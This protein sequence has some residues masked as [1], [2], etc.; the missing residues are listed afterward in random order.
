MVK[1]RQNIAM[2]QRL[3]RR[4]KIKYILI[5]LSLILGG[6]GSETS[7]TLRH[8]DSVMEEHPDSAMTILS[9]IRRHT[10]KDSDLPYFALLYT[11]AQVK[12]DVPLDSDSLISIAYAKYGADTRGDRGIRS[13]FYTG[14]VFFNQKRYREAMPYYLTAYEES[15]RLSNDYW[16]AKA[17]ERINNVFFFTYNYD[18]AIKYSH[19]AAIYYNESGRKGNHRYALGQM[20]LT[21]VYNGEAERA[22]QLLD[23]LERRIVDETPVDSALLAYLK[24]PLI[25]AMVMTGRGDSIDTEFMDVSK[26]DM[27]NRDILDATILKSLIYE[28]KDRSEEV[29]DELSDIELLATSNED[30][31]HILYARYENA[32]SIGDQSLA[33]SLVDSMLYYQNMVAEEII[34]GSVTG[35]QRDF[36]SEMSLRHENRSRLLKLTLYGSIGIF[37]LLLV[38]CTVFF[39]LKIRARKAESEARLEA[40]LSLKSSYDQITRDKNSLQLIVKEMENKNDSMVNEIQSL[41]SAG[42]RLELNHNKIVEK[43]FKDKWATLDT[44]CDQY[45]GLGNSELSAKD[46][47]SNIE[48]ELKKI[49]SK[50]GLAEIVISV[51]TYMGEIITDLRTQCPFLKDADVNFIALLYAGFSVRAVCM[52]TGIKYPYF[53]VKKSRLIKR[54]E[55][56]DAPDKSLFLEKLK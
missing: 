24:L 44:L 42:I 23:S 16:H 40:F 48:K 2:E 34:I 19:E 33:L 38:F 31:I 25:D 15:K 14:E 43:L 27:S 35:A 22:F 12:T 49:V 54:I 17:A 46:L 3:I 41:Q 36:Y 55:T 10:L 8:A 18:D 45:F 30:K 56:S 20:A 39:I 4:L 32:K 37:V 50:K 47:V 7:R 29:R 52:F 11:Q 21:L 51:D 53:Y 6:C 26:E 9:S 28:E 5:I 13:N 1:S